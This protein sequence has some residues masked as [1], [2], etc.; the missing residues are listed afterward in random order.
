MRGRIWCFIMVFI[1]VAVFPAEHKYRVEGMVRDKVSRQVL[2]YATVYVEELGFGTVTGNDGRYSF[3]GI[4]GGDYRVRVQY[5]G[6]ATHEEKVAVLKDMVLEVDMNRFS[7]ELNEVNV[8]GESRSENGSAVRIKR[9]ALEYI[10]P[11]SLSDIFQLLPGGLLSDG[12]LSKANQVTTRQ[13]GSDRNTAFGMAVV[14]DGAPLSNN[15]NLQG[16][17][18]DD[19]KI[20]ERSVLNGGIDLRMLSTDHLEEAEVIRGISSVKYGDMSSGVVVLKSKKGVSPWQVRMKADPL[21][22]LGY[23]GKG[24]KLPGNGG[25]LHAGVDVIQSRPD[26]RERLQKYTRVSSQLSYANRTELAG[27]NLNYDVALRYYSTLESERSDPDL[28]VG[29]DSYNSH[30]NRLFFTANAGWEV[31][32]DWLNRLNLTVSADYT[33]DVLNRSMTVTPKGIVP[34]PVSQAEGESEGVFLPAEY[35]SDFREENKPV[36]FF[37]RVDGRSVWETNQ[38]V[39]SFLY[40]VEWRYD[41]NVGRGALYDLTRPPYPGS[42]ASSRPRSFRSVPAMVK[43]ALFVEDHLRYESGQHK[44]NLSVGVRLTLPGNLPGDYRLSGRVYAEPRVN[45]SYSL[46]SFQLFGLQSVFTLRAGYGEQVKFPSLDYLYPDRAWFDVAAAN[47]YSQVPENRFLWV[48]TKVE[49]RVN[50]ALDVNRVRKVEMGFDW[51]IGDT[52]LSV[53]GFY[54]RSNDGYMY[55]NRYVSFPYRKYQIQGAL[56]N[57]KP[58]LEDFT[59]SNDTLLK[60]YSIPVNAMR[61]VKKGIEY[62]VNF[63]EIMPI[64]TKIGFNGAYYHT[65]YD[66]SEPE[67]YQPSAYVNGKPYPYAGVYDWNSNSRYREQ[68]NTTGW[69][70]THIPE[71]RLHF[72]AFVQV[73]WFTTSQAKRFSGMPSAYIGPDG[74]SRPFTETE[75]DNPDFKQLIQ[76]YSASYFNKNRE[77]LSVGI[78]LKATKE[79]G[80]NLQVSF[81]VNR[82]W[83][84]NPV[85]KNNLNNEVRKWEIPAF[86]AELTL[87]L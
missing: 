83:D 57:G 6:Y 70:D 15:G 39:H 67:S 51:N 63:P 56:P 30:Y 50:E 16:F 78:N 41:K 19:K 21:N 26:V 65:T 20:S 71:F 18:V 59:A 73:V 34:L 53:T 60:S 62:Q 47:Y 31:N 85:Y 24:F 40:G 86:G 79:I 42:A 77:P 1:P 64:R 69:L 54:E 2:E 5:L 82:L 80:R 35:L 87:K 61:V 81:F 44:L 49:D 58:S 7:L 36:N 75:R 14:M 76:T 8:M 17:S 10:Q 46:P 13:A 25:T 27:R 38:V 48:A 11:S 37:G 55:T 4:P 28:T 12:N 33:A 84:Y 29:V 52:R 45:L 32:S 22:K 74:V 23:V 43:N 3:E 9:E 66:V 68:L 72:T